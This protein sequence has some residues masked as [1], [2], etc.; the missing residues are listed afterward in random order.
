MLWSSSPK[1]EG[2]SQA[3]LAPF[4]LNRNMD[5]NRCS[6][7]YNELPCQTYPPKPSNMIQRMIHW[8]FSWCQS[9]HHTNQFQECDAWGR[10]AP[11]AQCLYCRASAGFSFRGCRYGSGCIVLGSNVLYDPCRPSSPHLTPGSLR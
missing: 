1:I 3:W 7:M 10:I 4:L 11:K 8:Q 5:V 2:V 6:I 9:E